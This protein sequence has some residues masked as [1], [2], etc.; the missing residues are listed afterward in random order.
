MSRATPLVELFDGFSRS[1]FFFVADFHVENPKILF[2][3]VDAPL[4]RPAIR[5]RGGSRHECATCTT[6]VKLFDVLRM[7]R[8]SRAAFSIIV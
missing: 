3:V 8:R 6:A 1:L 7:S 4:R 5:A 2:L